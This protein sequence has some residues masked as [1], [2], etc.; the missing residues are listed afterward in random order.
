MRA[1]VVQGMRAKRCRPRCAHDCEP[2]GR[3]AH[4]GGRLDAPEQRRERKQPHLR[5]HLA[6][7]AH[8]AHPAANE[9]ATGTL[10]RQGTRRTRMLAGLR[11]QSYLDSRICRD[12]PVGS[13]RGRCCEMNGHCR[14]RICSMW[15][16]SGG[17]HHTYVRKEST[18]RG[19]FGSSLV[20]VVLAPPSERSC[21][22]APLSWGQ[23][24]RNEKLKPTSFFCN[25]YRRPPSGWFQ[26]CSFLTFL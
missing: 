3:C 17:A 1:S 18:A 26:M 11:M 9:A 21:L 8:T 13:A 16:F 10:V 14:S 25:F 7:E 6:T 19:T 22:A 24:V 12:V 2:G 23:Q 15:I 5:T 4:G 20:A